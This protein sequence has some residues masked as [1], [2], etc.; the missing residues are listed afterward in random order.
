MASQTIMLSKLQQKT[1]WETWLSSEMRANYFADMAG[2]YQTTQKWLTWLTLIF[3]SG[4][5][6]A[7]LTSVPSS[8]SWIKPGLALV[9]VAVSLLSLVWQNQKNAA[10]CSDLHFRWSR[11]ASEYQALWDDMYSDQAPQRFRELDEK[12][13]ELSKSSMGIPYKENRMLKWEDYVL[14]HHGIRATA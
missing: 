12:S 11:L 1:V 13:A 7:I 3:S 14:R 8:W 10:E 4:V 6:A 5:F 9:T 2:R